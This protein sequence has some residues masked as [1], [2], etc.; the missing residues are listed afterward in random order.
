MRPCPARHRPG[1][2]LA[3]V[4]LLALTGAMALACFL[5]A[6]GVVFLGVAR[7][8]EAHRA[9]EGDW[10]MRGAMIALAAMCV[11]IGL[12]PIVF[13]PAIE[14]AVGAW[15]SEWTNA[16]A[17]PPLYTLGWTHVAVAVAASVAAWWLVQR[18][19]QGVRFGLTWDCAYAAPTPRMQYTAASFA[20]IITGWFSFI[21]RPES[22]ARLPLEALPLSASLIAHTPETVLRYIV[23]P[24]SKRIL[25]VAT[26]A[27]SL[28]HGGV[29]LYLLYLLI[30][31][32]GLGIVVI[33]GGGR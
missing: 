26:A 33:L 31:I 32:A 21:L 14:T 18:S 9:H 27:R 22:H 20:S 6:C 30:G 29:Q 23:E 13:W 12:A 17:P 10:Y 24:L 3:A 19:R 1:L 16:A 25:R 15:R 28:Q 7:S 5:K 8:P 11:V 2:P 4:V